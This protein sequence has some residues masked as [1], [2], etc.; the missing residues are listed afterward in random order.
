MALCADVRNGKAT[1]LSFQGDTH[2]NRFSP[3]HR[4][5]PEEIF[6][7]NDQCIDLHFIRCSVNS[8]ILGLLTDSFGLSLGLKDQRG[9]GLLK[10]EGP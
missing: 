7:C 8:S 1:V 6:L 5:G 9:A 3:Y 2:E 4:E 10:N